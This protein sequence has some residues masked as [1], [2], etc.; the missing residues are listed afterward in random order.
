M[1]PEAPVGSQQCQSEGEVESGEIRA[2]RGSKLRKQKQ[3]PNYPILDK[4]RAGAP[5][6]IGS[7]FL[8]SEET[9]PPPNPLFSKGWE[10]V[11]TTGFEPATPTPPV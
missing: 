6:L 4:L 10:V 11:G 2:G 1:V 7:F 3:E 8:F 5:A 9:E